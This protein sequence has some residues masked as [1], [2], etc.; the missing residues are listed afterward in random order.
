MK[1]A[2]LIGSVAL[3]ALSLA[4]V[5][6]LAQR[7]AE[8]GNPETET[9]PRI[10]SHPILVARNARDTPEE[11]ALRRKIQAIMHAGSVDPNADPASAAA[12]AAAEE[13]YAALS[14]FDERFGTHVSEKFFEEENERAHR[15]YKELDALPRIK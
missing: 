8:G 5:I 11:A 12:C 1:V 4:S 6:H 2:A 10:S 7:R 3:T 15:V 9:L 14:R 13:E